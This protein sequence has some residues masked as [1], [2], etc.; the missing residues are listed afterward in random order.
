MSVVSGVTSS[1]ISLILV[2]MIIVS[3]TR[4]SLNAMMKG[5]FVNTARSIEGDRGAKSLRDRVCRF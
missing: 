4:A 3:S 2:N 1:Y 5:R